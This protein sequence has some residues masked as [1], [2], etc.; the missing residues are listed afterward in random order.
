LKYAKLCIE[1]KKKH[2]LF[3]T[4]YVKIIIIKELS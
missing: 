3:M 1:K 4:H 2:D